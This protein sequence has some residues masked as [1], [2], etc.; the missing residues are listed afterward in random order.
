M[1]DRPVPGLVGPRAF[2]WVWVPLALIALV[3]YSAPTHAHWVHD[4]AR[5]A[6]YLPIVMAGAMGGVR[7]GLLAAGVTLALYSPHAIFVH[8][9]ADPAN[10]TEKLLEMGFYVVLGVVSGAVSERMHR[11]RERLTELTSQLS[12]T[13]EE[14]KARDALLARTARLESLGQLTAGLAHEIRN[15]LHAMRGTA[16]ILLDAIPPGSPEHNLGTAHISEIDRL[17]GV[18]RRFLD[19]ARPREPALT[20]V[21]LR[22]VLVQVADLLR[23]QASRQHTA[24][25]V[26]VEH[27]CIV[28]GDRDQLVQVVLCIAINALQA[29]GEGGRLGL[30]VCQ[31][32]GWCGMRVE[33]DGPRIPDELIDRIFDPFVTTRDEGIGLG[34]ATAWRIVEDHGGRLAVH[35]LDGGV[36]FEVWLR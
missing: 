25:Q 27:G 28:R 18:L 9:A 8:L 14:V 1:I 7:W 31:R 15:P 19:F 3:H 21:D 26:Q 30:S 23:A 16:E 4:V 2:L 12:R 36:A 22:L 13:V 29:R 20:E 5:R 24:I 11:E 10:H 34:L 17:S 35:N 6:F 33:N 32:E